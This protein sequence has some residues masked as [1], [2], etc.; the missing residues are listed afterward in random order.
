MP[1]SP[2]SFL[3]SLVSDLKPVAPMRQWDGMVPAEL[4]E[5]QR[6]AIGGTQ[7]QQRVDER[8]VDAFGEQVD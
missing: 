2:D 8:D 7:E 5:E 6:W 3:E 1:I 4:L